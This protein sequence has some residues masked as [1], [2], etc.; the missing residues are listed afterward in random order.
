MYLKT[1]QVERRIALKRLAEALSK[2]ISPASS[3]YVT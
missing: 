1:E 3:I 2:I